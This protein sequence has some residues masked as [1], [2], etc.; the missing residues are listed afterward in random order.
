MRSGKLPRRTTLEG[1]AGAMTILG[2][3]SFVWGVVSTYTLHPL[4][5]PTELMVQGVGFMV[6]AERLLWLVQ[7]FFREG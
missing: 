1:I 5:V 4:V 2:L 6:G 7:M 3:A